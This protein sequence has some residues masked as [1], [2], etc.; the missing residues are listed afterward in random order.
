MYHFQDVYDVTLS[1][2][3]KVT[4]F[5]K[6]GLTSKPQTST[7]PT[8]RAVY[9]AERQNQAEVSAAF[10]NPDHIL[11]HTGESDFELYDVRKP[12]EP[13]VPVSRDVPVTRIEFESHLDQEGRVHRIKE[14]QDRVFGGGIE[15]ELRKEIWPFL[16]NVYGWDTT[17]L[18]RSQIL[19]DKRKEYDIMKEQWKSILPCQVKRFRYP[20]LWNYFPG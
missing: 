10:S 1:G 3:S 9:D 8:A 14:L 6:V 5:I 17:V 16:L 13:T 18:E 15:P 2:L 7:R 12:L 20:Y 19:A 4:N 11:H